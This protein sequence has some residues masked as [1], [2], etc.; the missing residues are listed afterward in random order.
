MHVPLEH[1]Q[2]SSWVI[3]VSRFPH[4]F[5]GLRWGQKSLRNEVQF[6]DV[7]ALR[8]QVLLALNSVQRCFALIWLHQK[9]TIRTLNPIQEQNQRKEEKPLP[10]IKLHI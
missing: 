9:W 6:Q 1:V 5:S 8:A 2:I 4:I 7:A 10:R 3:G